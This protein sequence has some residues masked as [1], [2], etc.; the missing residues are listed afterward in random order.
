M[1]LS[2]LEVATNRLMPTS[3]AATRAGGM[4]LSSWSCDTSQYAAMRGNTASHRAISARPAH[5]PGH[6]A[7]RF[8]ESGVRAASRPERDDFTA[9][10]GLLY[11]TAFRTPK[12]A[13]TNTARTNWTERRLRQNPAKFVSTSPRPV[14]DR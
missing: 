5:G 13:K 2:G 10:Y 6:R 1:T 11:W 9:P 3:A 12:T 7:V 4:K 14:G 8:P